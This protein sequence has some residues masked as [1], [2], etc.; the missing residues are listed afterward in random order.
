MRTSRRELIFGLAALLAGP[1]TVLAQAAARMRRVA[2]VFTGSPASER[3]YLDAL[4][5]GLRQHGYQEGGN[6]T[7][8][9]SYAEG[10]TD[11]VIA[12]IQEA[13]ARKPDVIATNGSATATAAKKA[14]SS[15]PVVM[16]TIG[17]P[18]ALG[19]AASLARPGGNIT[20]NTNLDTSFLPKSLEILHETL[21]AVRSIAVLTDPAMPVV[22]GIWSAVDAT[23]KKL[24]VA[25]ERFD[26]STPEDIDRMLGVL[27]KRH[28]G[29]LLVFGTPLFHAHRKRMIESLAR[30]R[31]PQFWAS[32]DAADL[33]ALMSYLANASDM[34]RNAASFVHR[35]LQG[36]KPGDLPFEQA[37]RFEFSINLK[38]AKTLGIKI[39]QSVLIRADRVIE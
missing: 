20:G 39:P 12:L 7:L 32:P 22:P 8:E 33:G 6:L 29:A 18:V 16:A 11:R 38:T 37:T 14:T 26:A 24:R 17:D 34:W 31:I 2:V 23:A 36:A 28:P 4:Q 19:L 21:P 3:I 5:Q 10:R 13:V 9:L 27:A 15:I 30:E 25:L 35:I 1:G